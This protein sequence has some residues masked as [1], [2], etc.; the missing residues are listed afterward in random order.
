MV[1]W[2]LLCADDIFFDLV[3]SLGYGCREKWRIRRLLRPFF[4][5][6]N[7]SLMKKTVASIR[8]T[9]PEVMSVMFLFGL[10]LFF[11]TMFGM[12]IFP[13]NNPVVQK[14][15]EFITDTQEG[16]MYFKDMGQSMMSLIVLLTTA[17]NPDV[18]MPAYRDN[19]LYAIYFIAYLSMGLYFFMNM[20]LAVIY[21]QFR[22]S[23]M[24]SLQASF[25]RRRL[26]IRTAFEVLQGCQL[27][28]TIMEFP[29]NN[30]SKTAIRKLL[31]QVYFSRKSRY[32]PMMEEYMNTVQTNSLN[33]K[34]FQEMFDIVFEDSIKRRPSARVFQNNALRKMQK[35]VMH[36]FFQY[37]GDLMA[38]LNVVLITVEITKDNDN[39]EIDS[40][41][42]KFNFCFILYYT[43][44]QLLMLFFVGRKRY[45]SH[46]HIWFEFL[47]TCLLVIVQI[48][49][50]A[51]Y[52]KFLN[53][54]GSQKLKEESLRHNFLS[55]W[56]LLR[57]TNMLII[58]RLLRIIPSIKPL[59]LVAGTLSD[60]IKNMRPFGGVIVVI[61]YVFAIFGMM[62][63]QGYSPKPNAQRMNATVN[64]Q[65]AI[66][67]L[68]D[69]MVVNNWHV[70]LRAFKKTTNNRGSQVYFV[71]WWFLSVVICA[72]LL[73]ALVLEA[74][75]TQYERNQ[76]IRRRRT[77]RKFAGTEET[78]QHFRVHQMFMSQMQEPTEE[79]LV[80]EIHQ[81]HYLQPFV[82]YR[83]VNIL[84]D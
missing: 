45:F 22:G 83:P 67:V 15:R 48:I 30:V 14:G 13:D 75:F 78:T 2:L 33:A 58:V 57:I 17:N 38:F 50:L 76:V 40:L 36:P 74:F 18:M 35:F 60:L 61:Y 31:Q 51:F 52:A 21:N 53:K 70:F 81:H 71:L 12:I 46:K 65:A 8:H 29:S 79:E 6:Q 80:E 16:K 32:L 26:G 66:V 34:Q 27:Y 4:I 25:F 56:N 72:N 11:F 7:S 28:G 43:I 9:L 44:E 73:I 63:F 77:R 5:L 69:I 68:W 20:L 84:D 82:T 23:F 47:V 1:N 49:Y 62:I 3:V 59:S 37:F 19:R 24:R 41:L 64:M 55:A 39:P 42:V 10:H 54:N